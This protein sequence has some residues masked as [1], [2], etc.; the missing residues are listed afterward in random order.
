MLCNPFLSRV[1]TW[2]AELKAVNPLMFRVNLSNLGLDFLPIF[3]TSCV[4]SS[5]HH[6]LAL[7]GLGNLNTRFLLLEIRT[8]YVK[9]NNFKHGYNHFP[10]YSSIQGFA[11]NLLYLLY[12]FPPDDALVHV[13]CTWK[14]SF[15]HFTEFIPSLSPAHLPSPLRS[16]LWWV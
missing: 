16:L 12:S 11:F 7:E 1:F 9:E 2:F 15:L 5:D 3:L 14:S 6:T 8:P 10:T 4:S 13:F